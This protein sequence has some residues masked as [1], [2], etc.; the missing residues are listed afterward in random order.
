M[1]S[2]NIMQGD[3]AHLR[4][5]QKIRKYVPKDARAHA[6]QN[7][8]IIGENIVNGYVFEPLVF[9]VFGLM[10]P[11][12]VHVLRMAALCAASYSARR[13]SCTIPSYAQSFEHS[14][15]QKLSVRLQKGNNQ[16][17]HAKSF[18]TNGAR[19][20]SGGKSASAPGAFNPYTIRSVGASGFMSE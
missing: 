6:S 15:M 19:I 5:Q 14:A 8:E 18:A 9:E 10:G 20:R 1:P 2:E 3:S 17:I 4:E 16:L 11:R 13:Y 7:G 12:T